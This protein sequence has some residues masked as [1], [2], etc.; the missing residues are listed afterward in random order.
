MLEGDDPLVIDAEL[1]RWN[2]DDESGGTLAVAFRDLSAHQEDLIQD[3]LLKALETLN[4]PT[5]GVRGPA[6]GKHDV[7]DPRRLRKTR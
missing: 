4:G 2:P 5:S 7:D 1:A 6:A 3:A